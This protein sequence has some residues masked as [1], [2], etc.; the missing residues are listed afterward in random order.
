MFAFFSFAELNVGG[1][2]VVTIGFLFLRTMV[3]S[4]HR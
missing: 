3:A 4:K 1:A 2:I